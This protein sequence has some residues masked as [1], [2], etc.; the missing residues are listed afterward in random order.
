MSPAQDE[1]PYFIQPVLAPEYNSNELYVHNNHSLCD[2]LQAHSDGLVNN[3]YQH[4]TNKVTTHQP[5]GVRSFN[6]L[7]LSQ[8]TLFLMTPL[9]PSTRAAVAVS[10]TA[11]VVNSDLDRTAGSLLAESERTLTLLVDPIGARPA[12]LGAFTSARNDV[13]AEP[14]KFGI[15]TVYSHPQLNFQPTTLTSSI[16]VTHSAAAEVKASGTLRS[17]KGRHRKAMKPMSVRKCSQC[18]CDNTTC[19]GHWRPG[20]DGPGSLCNKC[21]YL[22]VF[23]RVGTQR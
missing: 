17:V 15:P 3:E 23:I 12:D 16:T 9:L 14:S 20:P 13:L 7:P 6:S 8:Q 19:R 11:V 10:T 21:V 1:D 5:P 2:S 22:S 4:Q 18:G